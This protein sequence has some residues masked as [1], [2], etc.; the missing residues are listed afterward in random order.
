MRARKVTRRA[1]HCCGYLL[2]LTWLLT[3]PTRAEAAGPF[4]AAD[5]RVWSPRVYSFDAVRSVRQTRTL[6]PGETVERELT[7]GQAHVY[8]FMLAA[9]NYMRLVVEQRGIDVAVLTTSRST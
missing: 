1:L 8:E 9:D 3:L 2:C 4:M 7:G 5:D 6:G